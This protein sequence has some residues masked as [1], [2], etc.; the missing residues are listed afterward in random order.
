MGVVSR[1]A[2]AAGTCVPVHAGAGIARSAIRRASVSRRA[3][4]FAPSAAVP[5]CCRR[6]RFH[7]VHRSRRPSVVEIAPPHAGPLSWMLMPITRFAAP[8][9]PSL[10]TITEAAN[11]ARPATMNSG[12]TS[13]SPFCVSYCWQSLPLTPSRLGHRGGSAATPARA[14]RQD[15]VLRVLQV[16][17]F[18]PRAIMYCGIV[19]AAVSRLLEPRVS[20]LMLFPGVRAGRGHAG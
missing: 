9:S 20:G 10:P 8:S 3:L 17:A 14:Y 4:D 15:D 2:K 18:R 11:N 7:Q 12:S 5:R 1:A 6:R 16:R 13:D 19:G